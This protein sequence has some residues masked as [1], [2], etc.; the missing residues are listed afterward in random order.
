MTRFEHSADS[1]ADGNV[2]GLIAAAVSWRRQGLPRRAL[3]PLIEAMAAAPDHAGARLEL[4][5]A[6]DEAGLP[7]ESRALLAMLARDGVDAAPVWERLGRELLAEGF[8]AAAE[9][10]LRRALTLDPVGGPQ[11]DL[12]SLSATRDGAES[13]D[14]GRPAMPGTAWDGGDCQGR[15]LLLFAGQYL[16]DALQYLR[17]APLV[18]ARGARVVLAVPAALTPLLGR[19]EGVEA[20]LA[21]GQSPPAGLTIDLNAALTEL[22]ALLGVEP[23][24]PW[25]LTVPEGRRRPV[26]APPTTRL[27]LGLAWMGERRRHQIPFPAL[28]PLMT[29]PEV[30][31]FSL[32]T[33]PRALDASA[34]AHPALI[35]DLAPTIGDFADLA[36]RIAE[37][38]LVITADSVVAHLAAMLGREVW[39]LLTA[40]ADLRWL[41]SPPWYPG[42]RLFRQSKTGD[43]MGVVAEARRA[44]AELRDSARF[45]RG[46]QFTD[47]DRAAILGG[48]RGLVSANTWRDGRRVFPLPDWVPGTAPLAQLDD[49]ASPARAEAGRLAAEAADC[50][51]RGDFTA[52]ARLC[53]QALAAD[54]GNIE[55]NAN[56]G[57]LIRRTGRLDAAIALTQ[58]ALA[59]GEATPLLSNLGNAL[60]EAGRLGEAEAILLK[61]LTA[62]PDNPDP[63]F[64]MA[65]V[66]RDRGMA[67]RA[68]AL[69]ERSLALRPDPARQRELAAAL[70]RTGAFA[71]GFAALAACPRPAPPPPALPVWDGGDCRGRALLVRDGGG[72]A[73]DTLTLAR[74]LP[75]LAERGARVVL[76]CPPDLAPLLATL[77]GVAATVSRGAP[78]PACDFQVALAELPHRLGATA[79]PPMPR[80]GPPEVVAPRGALRVGLG[81]SERLPLTALL[82][83]AGLPGV[84]LV[85]LRRGPR[86][87]D[88]ATSGAG[89][90]ITDAGSRC[91]DLV[92]LA[93][94]IARLDLMVGGDTIEVHLA[95]AIGKPTW[96]LLPRAAGWSWPEDCEEAPWHPDVRMF[97]Q[98]GDGGWEQAVGRLARALAIRAANRKD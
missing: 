9:P 22:P 2:E 87:G 10:C 24:P 81:W 54:P 64:N 19:I 97:P 5:L 95:A 69:L 52:A 49:A 60:R 72:D 14:E 3:A 1:T 37:M 43:W 35:T 32:Q 78:A 26:L 47:G 28:M 79:P 6:L 83:L 46:A 12:D 89:R 98:D 39:L 93:A 84:A 11:A 62:A 27:K 7:D 31:C 30:A 29:L 50:Q 88:L 41:T 70:L 48:G 34:L 92:A 80:L 63:L 23:P 61:A 42:T 75:P 44:L 85:G 53:G 58:R 4:A 51:R 76:E 16:D 15:T 8:L 36:A 66:E 68:R 74:F 18:E 55:A 57:V 33:G 13:P 45:A 65:L 73:I 82:P 17:F 67:R 90:F 86:A 77:P 21:F 96:V 20:V 25:P 94:E 40:D 91:L 59:G 71:E 38:D 56:L